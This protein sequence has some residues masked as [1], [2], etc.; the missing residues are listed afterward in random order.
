M[1]EACSGQV[2]VTNICICIETLC[3]APLSCSEGALM[4]L[5]GS[6][7]LRELLIKGFSSSLAAPFP[8]VVFE[9]VIVCGSEPLFSNLADQIKKKNL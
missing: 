5:A 8:S 4:C 7:W 2:G 9:L 6:V 1:Y 3:V